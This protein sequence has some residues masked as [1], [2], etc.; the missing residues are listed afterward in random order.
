MK[1][2]AFKSINKK[3]IASLNVL[4]LMTTA[5]KAQNSTIVKTKILNET[6]SKMTQYEVKEGEVTQFR[7]TLSDYVVSAIASKENIMAEAFFE[8]KNPNVLWLIERW[9]N[10]NEL[11]K[12]GKKTEAKSLATL[13]E[14]SL[15]KPSKTYFVKDLEPLTKEQW[16]KTAKKEDNQLVIMLFV[17]AKKGTQ[18]NF[19]D[20]YHIAMPQF[21]SEPGVV[22]YQLSE[23]E[24]DDTQFVTYEKFRSNDAFQYHLNF[25]PIKPVIE[26]LET[27]I[28]TQPFQNGLH[29]LIEFAPLTRE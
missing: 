18:Q 14:K 22:T 5:T 19:K 8:E 28:K 27:S 10:K 3:I 4:V 20:T 11:E 26:Y 21:R 7:K 25:P 1:T 16:R 24:G 13:A 6:I 2:T 15:L 23:I 17:D 12:F 9:N 29:N